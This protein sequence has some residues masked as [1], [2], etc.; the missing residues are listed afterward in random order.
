MTDHS[1]SVAAADTAAAAARQAATSAGEA[2]ERA[3]ERER[4]ATAEARESRDDLIEQAAAWIPD[5][6]DLCLRLPDEDG[7][8]ID[9][10]AEQL[11]RFQSCEPGQVLASLDVWSESVTEVA[12]TQASRALA[13]AETLR[14]SAEQAVS[15]AADLRQKAAALRAGELLPL[16][17]PEWAGEVDRG[18]PLLGEVL[19]WA[20]G[21]DKALR[22]AVE[23]A[24]ADSGLLG[25]AL[26]PEGAGNSTW[27]ATTIGPVPARNLSEVLT[28]DEEHPLAPVAREVLAR[29]A[30]A[31][32]AAPSRPS[33]HR[34]VRTSPRRRGGVGERDP[35]Q[36]FDALRCQWVLLVDD[37]DLAEV[38]RRDR[39]DG[40]RRPGRVARAF[41]VQCCPG[42]CTVRQGDLDGGPKC[43][44]GTGGPVQHLPEERGSPVHLPRPQLS[45][46][47]GQELTSPA[48]PP[49]SA[50]VGSLGN[51]P[52]L[53]R[54]VSRPGRARLAWVVAASVT[55]SLQTLPRE[56]STCPGSQLRM[57]RHSTARLVDR[58]AAPCRGG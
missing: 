28:V 14:D 29:I 15:D 54:G 51:G 21:P 40:G 11:A 8:A 20:A 10:P 36:N 32:T 46:R 50:A 37:E 22:A 9:E 7:A 13:Q 4:T 52:R 34:R 55:D 6:P 49:L 43:L 42:H 56:A 38:P 19:N 5:H 53:R 23:V 47:Q 58:R 2:R 16:P 31:D 17:R 57:G 12:T 48:E 44:V 18:A 1:R 41:W 3:V 27:T 26:H 45:S 30:L 24:L 39:S 35:G 33:G 25:A